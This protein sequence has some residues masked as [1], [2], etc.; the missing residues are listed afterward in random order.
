MQIS[1]CHCRESTQFSSQQVP[2]RLLSLNNERQGLLKRTMTIFTNEVIF[3][4]TSFFIFL[5]KVETLMIS[6]AES[7]SVLVKYCEILF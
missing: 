1:L 2:T 6:D 7:C 5:L 4:L 3:Y